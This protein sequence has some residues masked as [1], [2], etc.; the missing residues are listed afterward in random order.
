[1][2]GDEE[3]ACKCLVSMERGEREDGE[4]SKWALLL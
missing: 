4:G 2:K 1:M 3:H